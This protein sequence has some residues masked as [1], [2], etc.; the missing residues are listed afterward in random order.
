VILGDESHI[1]IHEAGGPSIIA[2][3]QT[4]CIPDTGGI[5]K[6]GDILKRLRRKDLHAPATSLIC[7]ENAHSLGKVA[8]LQ[9][10][11][12]VRAI[13]DKW[14]LPVHLDGARIFN[15]AVALGCGAAEIAGKADS[16]MFCL[17][18]GLCAPVGSLLAGTKDFIAA[19]RLK[20][21]ILGGGMRQTGILAVAGII[22]LKDHTKL[23]EDDHRRAKKLAEGLGNINGITV[24]TD[25]LDINLVFFSHPLTA[26]KK[27]TEDVVKHF[28]SRG[29]VINP[30][31]HGMFRFVT[32]YWIGDR[33][34]K[35]ILSA[36]QEAFGRGGQI[37]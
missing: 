2:G 16:V 5:L 22:A 4:R 1:I 25:A 34:I 11:G 32:H 35:K 19:A 8:S 21:K 20:R 12:K 15:A 23:L 10:M 6:S 36:A 30:P 26:S 31:S 13:A 37:R 14:D 18:K 24:N 9:S 29:I 17:S 3:V 7:I 33:E 27:L 28:A